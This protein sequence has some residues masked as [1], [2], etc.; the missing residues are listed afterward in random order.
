M[1]RVDMTTRQWHELIMPV[2]PHVSTDDEVPEIC[3]VR[4]EG[5]GR[6]V[7]AVGTDRYTLAATR[8]VLD[9]PCDEF[10]V[11]V[12]KADATAML[13]LFAYTKD[14]DPRLRIVVGKA[15]LPV[16]D[17]GDTVSVLSVTVESEDG[18]RLVIRDR[19][20]GLGGWRKTLAALV[21]RDLAPAADRLLLMPGQLGRWAA[22]ARK[23]DRL[24]VFA[25]PEIGDAILVLAE[26]HF[27]GAWMP[28]SHIDG[29][30]D[31]LLSDSPWWSELDPRAGEFDRVT[32]ERLRDVVADRARAAGLT[33]TTDG[34]GTPTIHVPADDPGALLRAA[35]EAG[36]D[37]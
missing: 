31:D 11:H 28:A 18:T 25:G 12:D 36:E 23:G 29:D 16:S 24:M 15:P 7:N 13:K 32:G 34:A 1:T 2:L 19:P 21:H 22:A 8:H 9:E 20:G 4:I 33:V 27:A 3:V 5:S 14:L 6:I 10:A 37:A 30:S 35:G 17:R 26:D